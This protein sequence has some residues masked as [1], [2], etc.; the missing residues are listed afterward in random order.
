MHGRATICAPQRGDDRPSPAESRDGPS[1]ERRSRRR[2][3]FSPCIVPQLR[4]F[5]WTLAALV[6][7][8][9]L[10]AAWVW[11]QILRVGL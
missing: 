4:W 6:G 1:A 2:R 8:C 9:L 11:A 7:L 3:S 5:A 10:L